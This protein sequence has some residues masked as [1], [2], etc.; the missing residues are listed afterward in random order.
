M[1]DRIEEFLRA[2]LVASVAYVDEGE[3]RIIPFLYLYEAGHLYIHGSPGS[4]T[5]RLLRDGRPVT[6]S[7]TLI[8]ALVASKTE[9]N[10]SANYRSA[11]VYGHAHRVADLDKKRRIMREMAARYFPDRESPRDFA[12]ASDDD[13]IRMELLAIEI[14]EA[15]A[16]FR[17]GGSMSP[18]DEDP[19]FPGTA[20]VR[21]I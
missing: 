20:F 19:S 18:E 10:H 21:P 15:Q 11:I 14:D 2:G 1:P 7:V 4:G 6:A 12:A 17:T 13:L 3:P 9:M 16:K 8:D 5:L